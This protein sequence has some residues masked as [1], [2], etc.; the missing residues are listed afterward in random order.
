MTQWHS[1]SKGWP[2][3]RCAYS[4]LEFLT[5]QKKLWPW[6]QHHKT[7][8]ARCT[9]TQTKQTA[10]AENRRNSRLHIQFNSPNSWSPNSPCAEVHVTRRRRPCPLLAVVMCTLEWR[11]MPANDRGSGHTSNHQ[12]TCERCLPPFNQAISACFDG[13][14]KIYLVEVDLLPKTWI[15]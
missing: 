5:S 6:N 7:I 14:C 3:L 9:I 2:R 1:L 12:T 10:K 4:A 11:V 13:G 15:R 8:W